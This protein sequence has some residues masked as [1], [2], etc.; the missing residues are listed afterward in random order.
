[1]AGCRAGQRAR[2]AVAVW[3]AL[4]SC[5][6]VSAIFLL[7]LMHAALLI[8]A[9]MVV[10]GFRYKACVPASL[11]GSAGRPPPPSAAL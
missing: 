2:M 11:R 3:A 6:Q 5:T 10:T 1:M 8:W 4:R 9:S 7:M